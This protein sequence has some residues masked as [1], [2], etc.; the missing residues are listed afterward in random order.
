MTKHITVSINGLEARLNAS[1]PGAKHGFWKVLADENGRMLSWAEV[2][3]EIDKYRKLGYEVIPT[4]DH[5]DKK[6]YCL[7]HEDKK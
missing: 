6:G 4:C 7:G 5:H 2:R 1:R 3:I